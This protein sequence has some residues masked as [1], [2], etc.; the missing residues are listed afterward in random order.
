MNLNLVKYNNIL[1][2]APEKAGEYLKEVEA[3]RK[4]R[5]FLVSIQAAYNSSK[6]QK[7]K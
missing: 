6:K 2:E 1:A 4:H 3:V 7:Q 5:D